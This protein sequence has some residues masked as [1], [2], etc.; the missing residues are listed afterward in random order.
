M[1]CHAQIFFSVLMVETRDLHQNLSQDESQNAHQALKTA[2][3]L[4]HKRR[5]AVHQKVLE[6]LLMLQNHE[7]F[8]SVKAVLV[9]AEI[10]ASEALGR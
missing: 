5:F 1:R 7:P 6:R 3:Q 9:A 2:T 4:L 8:K 10:T